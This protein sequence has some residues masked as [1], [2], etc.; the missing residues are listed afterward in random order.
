[1]KRTRQDHG[2][3][4]QPAVTLPGIVTDL[5]R[6]IVARREAGDTRKAICEALGVTVGQVQRAEYFCRGDAEGRKLLAER[7]DSIVGLAAIGELDGG[8][9]DRLRFH[10]YH[11]EGSEL[12]GLSD[13]AALGRAYV[14]RIHGIGPKSLAS[15]DRA[16]GLFGMTWAPIDRT[17]KPKRKEPEQQEKRDHWG[18]ILRHVAE[19]EQIAGKGVLKE[20]E[21]RDSMEGVVYRLAFLNGYLEAKLK[22]ERMRTGASMRDITPEPEGDDG[23]CETAGNLVCLPGVRLADVLTDGGAA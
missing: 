15:I 4:G 8:A 16:L 5:D 3:A 2:A 13:V 21:G 20:I 9:S 17:P 7:P 6:Q 12:A 19:L 1:M 14:S 11:H 10:H 18:S 23:D 22:F